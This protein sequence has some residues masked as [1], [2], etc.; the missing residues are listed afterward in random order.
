M[1]ELQ[2]V[3][4]IARLSLLLPIILFFFQK[5]RSRELWVIYFYVLFSVLRQILIQLFSKHNPTV[6]EILGEL[7]PLTNYLFIGSFFYIANENKLD[8]KFIIIISVLYIPTQFFQFLFELTDSSLSIISTIN[9]L[10][11]LGFCL[12]YFYNQLKN[13]DITFIYLLPSFWITSAIFLFSSGTFFVFWYNLL[14]RNDELF[15]YQ[16][17]YIHAIIYLIRNII[18]SIA[19]IIKPYKEQVV[20]YS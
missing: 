14:Y 7:N 8:K 4:N 13:P 16:Y 18:F 5:N 6:V 15:T 10:I 9:T 19:L 11:V 12:I 3:E 1:G 2:L 17:V 20:E